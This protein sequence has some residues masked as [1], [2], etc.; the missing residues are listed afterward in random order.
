MIVILTFSILMIVAIA[1]ARPILPLFG[2]FGILL[3]FPAF[4]L[5][6]RQCLW[7]DGAF[8]VLAIVAILCLVGYATVFNFLQQFNPNLQSF[9]PPII[10]FFSRSLLP[11]FGLDA[12]FHNPFI[13]L[14]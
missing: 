4:Y 7:F 10:D 14:V 11:K 9:I 3:V 5:L 13:Y 12:I 6:A 1:I 2:S 8:G